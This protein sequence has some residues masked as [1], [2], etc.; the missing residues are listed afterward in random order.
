M[1]CYKFYLRTNTLGAKAFGTEL[2]A[3]AH[4]A[5][6]GAKLDAKLGA[7]DLGA[8]LVAEAARHHHHASATL[9]WA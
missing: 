6:L 5:D 8:D 1:W 3:K 4:G 7:M 2:G 9:N